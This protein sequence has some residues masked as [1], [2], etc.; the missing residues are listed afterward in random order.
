MLAFLLPAGRRFDS[1]RIFGLAHH[2][3][4]GAADL[5]ETGAEVR[6]I[7]ALLRLHRLNRAVHTP[8]KNAFTIG[9]FLQC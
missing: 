6:E 3:W 9:L 4:H 7:I 2:A 5:L 1:P 8:E